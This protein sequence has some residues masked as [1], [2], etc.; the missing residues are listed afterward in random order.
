MTHSFRRATAAD[1][2]TIIALLADY[3]LGRLRE[4][5]ASPP[6]AR[7]VAAFAASTRTRTSCSRLS[8]VTAR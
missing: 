3:P 7:Y 2:P 6:D 4:G 1:L 5:E 8:S